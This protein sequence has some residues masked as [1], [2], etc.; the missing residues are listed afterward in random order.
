MLDT[1]AKYSKIDNL[2]IFDIETKLYIGNNSEQLLDLPK[3]EICS[4]VLDIYVSMSS[5]N[6]T[7]EA[8]EINSTTTV[9][10]NH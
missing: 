4:E 5:M 9:K 10:M 6:G 3:Y 1:L 8:N 2:Y 7:S